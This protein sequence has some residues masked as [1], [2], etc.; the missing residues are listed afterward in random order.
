[1]RQPGK[2]K[3]NLALAFLT[4]VT[5][6]GGTA[7]QAVA[8]N[9]SPPAAE[10]GYPGELINRPVCLND[11]VPPVGPRCGVFYPLRHGVRAPFD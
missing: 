5:L 9:L 7:S 4:L 3:S 1:M 10:T 8:T 11:P 6:T 2:L